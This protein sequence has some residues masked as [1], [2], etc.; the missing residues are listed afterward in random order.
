MPG[1]VNPV[2]PEAVVQVAAQVMGNDA[3]VAFGGAQGTFELNVTMPM[4][5]RNVLGSIRLLANVLSVFRTRCIDGIEADEERCR[6]YAEA[7]P[8]IGTSLNPYLGYELSAE[9][10]KESVRTG[11]SIRSIVRERGLMTDAQLDQALDVLGMTKG[12]LR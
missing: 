4:M 1:K 11:R 9:V 12:G 10:I 7:S 6:A 5:A 2:L 3:A 8:S